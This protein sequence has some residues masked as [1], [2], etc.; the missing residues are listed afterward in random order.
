MNVTFVIPVFNERDTLEPLA[1]GIAEHVAPHSY[2]ILFVDDGSTD[3]SYETMCAL[4]EK[5][6]AID[7][8]RLRGNFG[9]SAALAAGFDRADGDVVFTMD[10][11]LQDEPREIPRFIAKMQEGFDVV[12]GWKA[13]RYDPIHKTVP[14]RIYN[15]FVAWLFSVPLHDVNCGFKLMRTEVVKKIQVYGEMHRLI[16]VLAHNLNYRVAEIPVEHHRRRYGKSKYGFERFTR[17]AMDVMTM[18]FLTKYRHAPGHFF[19]KLGVIQKLLGFIVLVSGVFVW[20]GAHPAVG[21][22]L[23]TAGLVL[24]AT[25]AITICIGLFAELMLRHFVRIDPALYVAED[26]GQDAP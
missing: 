1:A 20:R 23:F 9:K 18:W 19:G 5:N 8:I 22:A 2:R 7:I 16:P 4:R 24:A 15:W 12:C 26:A 10:S 13:K 6:P 11:D 17:G 25:G 3:G 21:A 14:S